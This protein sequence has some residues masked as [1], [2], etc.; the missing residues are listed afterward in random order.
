LLLAATPGIAASGT[1]FGAMTIRTQAKDLVLATVMLPLLAPSILAGVAG[2]RA[3]ILGATA[4]E[5]F[6]YFAL[7]G[8]FGFIFTA[9]GLGLFDAVVEG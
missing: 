8:L 7:L 5:L 3:L 6:D 2:T 9:G 4:S 1:L